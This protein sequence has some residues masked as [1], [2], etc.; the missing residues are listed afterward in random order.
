MRSETRAARQ[1]QIEIS[2]YALL[3]EKGY[4]GTSMLSVARHARCSNETLY[5]WYGDKVGLFR[6]MVA[7]NAE[8]ARAFLDD[9]LN[10]QSHV[11]DSLR[12][13]GPV[14]LGILLGER[15]IALN[16]AAAADSTGELADAVRT[17]G[18]GTIQPLLATLFEAARQRGELAF[19]DVEE[20]VELY[21]GVLI[22][23]MQIRCVV[24][25]LP[26]PDAADMERRSARASHC[27]GVLLAP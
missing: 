27:I 13:F 9:A 20:A 8:E 10:T 6:A 4:L 2:A 7:R 15:A 25:R 11:L 19:D 17:A 14:L 3:E 12:V 21:L 18:R 23:D 22:G 1:A 5:N 16:R 26:P 24:G